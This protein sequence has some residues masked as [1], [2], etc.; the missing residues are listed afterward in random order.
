ME[1]FRAQGAGHLVLISSV[2]SRPRHAGTPDGVRRE[3]GRGELAG[4]GH[5]LRRLR[6][7]DRGLDDPA[8]LHRDRHQR[9]PARP[10]HR[11]P[12]QGRGRADRRRSSASRCAATCPSG[13]GARSP[14]CCACCRSRSSAASPETPPAFCT[15]SW[16]AGELSV[17]KPSGD[18]TSRS[19]SAGRGRPSRRPRRTPPRPRR[20]AGADQAA[21]QAS[22][23]ST[24]GT[25][26]GAVGQRR[27]RRP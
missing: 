22:S 1:L 6:H 25:P 16:R 2:A 20:S 17:P 4:R 10:V 27:P 3:Q 5:P 14:G 24:T 9:R 19:A 12:R 26:A 18:L 13:R 21:A 7:A 23:A 8:R 11:R 15:V